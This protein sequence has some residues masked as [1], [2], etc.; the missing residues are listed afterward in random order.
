[1][2]ANLPSTIAGINIP[3]SHLISA[4]VAYMNDN[5]TPTVANHVMRSMVFALVVARKLSHMATVESEGLVIATLLH[6]L[7]WSKNP[8]LISPDKRFEVDGANAARGFVQEHIAADT[9]SSS[10][11]SDHRLSLLWDAI[12]LHTTPSISLHK[13]P[14][15]AVVCM[16]ITS[17]FLG[18]N[19]PGGLITV[20]EYKETV[21]AYPRLGFAGELK[22]IMCGLC[23]D[24]PET[25]YD[26]FVGHFGARDLPGYKEQ[27]E[28]NQVLGMLEGGLKMCEQYE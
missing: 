22:G 6:D 1:M 14:E 23:R 26:N 28:K 17:D 11:W 16:G 13:Q 5:S 21:R 20:D 19:M 12:A 4:A 15:V 2:M 10:K 18:P 8:S 27:W 9:S 7:G 24:K 25:T 3:T